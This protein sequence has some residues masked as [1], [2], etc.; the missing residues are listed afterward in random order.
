M[1][2]S[3][4]LPALLA[5]VLVGFLFT[6]FQCGSPALTSAKLYIKGNDWENAEKS[7][8]A[9]V[10]K[11]P[12]NAEAWYL[13][14][15]VRRNLNNYPGMMEAF[16]NSVKASPEFAK[17]IDETKLFVWGGT[18]KRAID[19]YNKSLKTTPDSAAILRQSAIGD[20]KTAMLVEPE[21]LVTY[22]N[23][24]LAY[25]AQGST[26]DQIATLKSALTHKKDSE[27]YI[28]LINAYIRKGENAKSAGNTDEASKSLND[29]IGA[30]NEARTLQ[31]DNS[32]LLGTLINVYIEADRAKEAVPLIREAITKDPQNKVFQ[33]DLGLLLMQTGDFEEATQHFEASVQADPN[34]EDG[35][36]N[37]A[38]AYMKW[39]DK[40]KKD[41]DPNSDSKLYVEKFKKAVAMTEKLVAIKSDVEKYWEGL[42]TAYANAGMGKEAQ[43]AFE[44]AEALKNK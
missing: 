3:I 21:S 17:K 4:V 13:L 27:V 20:Y 6:G 41:A 5:L 26:D 36:W 1:K 8:S 25:Q 24:A 44:K 22:Q 29:A 16:D 2:N 37:G 35:L 32:D 31:P 12:A 40:L 30:L 34:Y 28:N 38:V 14:G 43:K 15:D 11:N 10:A 33:N 9:E 23:L 39:G 19:S 7:L 18:I 42:A